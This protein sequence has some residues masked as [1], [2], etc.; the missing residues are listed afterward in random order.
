MCGYF[1]YTGQ[2]F[3]KNNL[4]MAMSRIKHRGPDDQT[5]KV[6]NRYALGHSRLAIQELDPSANQPYGS[7]SSF[8]L[9]NGEVY[10]KGELINRYCGSDL[11]PHDSD[12]KLLYYLIEK[13]GF[14]DAVSKITG[15]YSI[16]FYDENNKSIWL[17]RDFTGEKPLYFRTENKSLSVSSD[18]RNL[19]SQSEIKSIS[20]IL[21][22]DIISN[23]FCDHNCL[24]QIGVQAL[25][26]GKILKIDLESYQ[27]KLIDGHFS[28]HQ[29]CL[30]QSIQEIIPQA[31]NECTISDRNVCVFLSGGIDSSLIAK[32]I[33]QR[34]GSLVAY[35]A[36]Y[37]EGVGDE[38]HVAEIFARENNIQL[39]K[40]LIT[41][42]DFLKYID[43][44][45][46]IFDFPFADPSII[47]TL[48][49]FEVAR[50]NNYRVVMTGDGGD[51][52]FSGYNRIIF[53]YRYRALLKI[54]TSIKITD[55]AKY[56]FKPVSKYF[57]KGINEV[58]AILAKIAGFKDVNFQKINALLKRLKESN[59]PEEFYKKSFQCSVSK[60]IQP[61]VVSKS[62]FEELKVTKAFDPRLFDMQTYLPFNVLYKGDRCSMYFGVESR[63]PL[64]H[65]KLLRYSTERDWAKEIKGRFGKI[66]L[67]M[68][69][70]A[71]TKST[72]VSR[73]HKTGFGSPLCNWLQRYVK[74]NKDLIVNE[75]SAHFKVEEVNDAIDAFEQHPENYFLMIWRMLCFTKWA[76]GNF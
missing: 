23:G 35:T 65:K 30:D 41:Y 5:V 29:E 51:E 47:S 36:F 54:I 68:C 73:R 24:S 62:R 53:Y 22:A 60:K 25:E 7:E 34:A 52:L 66:T 4:S 15:M 70:S 9:Y 44:F 8:I 14:I 57:G 17:A 72:R 19:Y 67:R 64:L 32:C 43:E 63:A 37:K 10:N 6:T 45:P 12:T 76:N 71:I 50:Q 3:E 28:E 74:E 38:S 42:E 16:L 48:K 49:L 61:L 75:L 13:Q 11:N 1:F 46:R 20:K 55:N 18:A 69:L 27:R 2:N 56:I 40:V 26:P 31:I 58:I 59:S 39:E 33:S 21:Q